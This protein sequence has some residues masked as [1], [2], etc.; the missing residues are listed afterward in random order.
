MILNGAENGKHTGIILSDFQKGFDP[1]AHNALLDKMRC[2][3]LSDKTIKWFHSYLT[4]R[5]FFRFIEHCVFRSR[6]H[7]LPISSRI[8]I[9]VF[10]V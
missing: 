6:D 1:L 4:N 5:A 7:K 2:I 9:R 3:D 8:F 10:I